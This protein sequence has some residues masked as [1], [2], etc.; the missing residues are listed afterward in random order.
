VEVGHAR[1]LTTFRATGGRRASASGRAGFRRRRRRPFRRETA[2]AMA[3][4]RQ[5]R[6]APA[7]LSYD[8]CMPISGPTRSPAINPAAAAAVGADATQ[9]LTYLAAANPRLDEVLKKTPGL[10]AFLQKNTVSTG[11]SESDASAPVR[12][13]FWN[14]SAATGK[15]YG[16]AMTDEMI[17]ADT[18]IAFQPSTKPGAM[19]DFGGRKF[20]GHEIIGVFNVG[21]QITGTTPVDGG[22]IGNMTIEPFGAAGQKATIAWAVVSIAPDGRVRGGGYPTTD[23]NGPVPYQ[24]NQHGSEYHGRAAEV[25]LGQ[26]ASIPIT[27]A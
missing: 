1:L 4:R 7:R 19:V 25:T 22:F 20:P 2:A 6:P 13:P 10:D 11:P 5:H 21:D 16:H 12:W 14:H 8:V 18:I 9:D 24:R 15:K 23:G 17:K 3:E 27:E 26:P